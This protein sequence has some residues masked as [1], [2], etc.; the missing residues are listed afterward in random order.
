MNA[1]RT[2]TGALAARRRRLAKALDV[3]GLILT[4]LTVIAAV[5]FAFPLYWAMVTTL[6]PETEVVAPGLGLWPKVFTLDAYVHV[7]TRTK[8][9]IW[10]LNSLV[11]SGA[12]TLLAARV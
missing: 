12:V 6:K 5:I 3:G 1:E 9:N 10:Y 7:L 11:T 4:V 8:I 2:A